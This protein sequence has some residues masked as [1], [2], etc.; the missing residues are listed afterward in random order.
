MD[1]FTEDSNCDSCISCALS[2][3]FILYLSSP[4]D[5]IKP[6]PI[7]NLLDEKETDDSPAITFGIFKGLLKGRQECAHEFLML[8]IN[9]I[10]D[11]PTPPPNIFEGLR[12]KVTVCNKCRDHPN[13]NP[14]EKIEPFYVSTFLVIQ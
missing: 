2:E 1:F 9:S 3:T 4:D 7:H 12:C 13:Y 11:S 10:Y 6:L 8:L 14:F 5:Y